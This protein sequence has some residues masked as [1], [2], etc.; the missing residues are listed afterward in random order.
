[1]KLIIKKYKLL[2]FALT[3]GVISSQSYAQNH[4][5]LTFIENKGQWP[6]TVKFS[7]SI[8]G[9]RLFIENNTLT[10]SFTDPT[11]TGK[12][13]AHSHLLNNTGLL[14][15]KEYHALKVEFLNTNNNLQTK[16]VEPTITKYNYFFGSDET[17]W[18]TEAKGYPKV[19][20]N[21]LY[22]GISLEI[23]SDTDKLKYDFIIAPGANPNCIQMQYDGTLAMK[24]NDETL[25][26]TTPY[27]LLTEVI[28]ASYAICGDIARNVKTN[29]KL[30]GKVVSF[31][32]SH[33]ESEESIV[34]DPLLIF[35]T[36][37][38]SVANNWGNTATYDDFGNGYS[39]G[40]T[41]SDR[42]GNYLGEFPATA[43]AFQTESGGGWDVAILKYDSAGQNLLYATHLGGG[44]TDVPQSLIV[45]E[46]GE[47]LIL[48]I[49]G[50]NDF[51]VTSN[52]YDQSF[53]GGVN[54]QLL[55]GVD[56]PTGS[57]LFIAKLS[58]DGSQLLASTYIGGSSNDGWLESENPL[59]K[60]YGDES[61]GDINFDSQGNILVS[62][63]TASNDFPTNNGYD[64]SYGGGSVD[65]VVFKFSPNLDNLQWSTF[66]GGTGA[67]VALSIKL[68]SLDNIFVA[69]GTTSADFPTT[70]NTFNPSYLGNADGWIAHITKQGDSLLSST[71]IG[72][73][74]YDQVFFL[75][76]DANGDVYIAGQTLGSYPITSGVF[77]QGTTGQ[78]IHKLTPDL[79]TSLFST[80]VSANNRTLPSISLTAFLVNDCDNIYLA[81]WGSPLINFSSEDNNNFKL[82]TANLPI[83]QDAFQSNSDGSSF[84]LMVLSGDASELL[85]ATH[86]GDANSSVHVDGGTS[87]FDKHGLVYHSVCASCFGDSMFPTTEGAWSQVNG[88]IGCNNAFFKFDLASLKAR[89][90][91][92]NLALDNPGLSG[93]CLP[94]HIAFENL[95]IGGD[96]Y[97]WDFG[98][99][100]TRVTTTLDTVVHQYTEAGTYQIRLRAS[101]VNTCISEDFAY[102]TIIVSNPAFSISDDVDI[103]QGTSTQLTALGGSIFLW[104]PV[105]GL[106]DSTIFNPVATPA[107]TTTYFVQI[108]N[109]NGCKH[110]DSVTVNVIPD[111]EI[112][113][114][115]EK[116]DLCQDS[117]K[118]VIINESE[119][120]TNISWEMGDG[121]LLDSGQVVYEYTEDGVYKILGKFKN[122]ACKK[123]V[124]FDLNVQKLFIPN[125]LTRNQDGLNDVLK[126]TSSTPVDLSIFTRW[127]TLV[128]E[129]LDYKNNWKGEGLNNGVYY[130]QV[131]LEN[132]EVCN[133]WI[134][135]LDGN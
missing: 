79:Q 60:N 33:V 110:Q 5:G 49:T 135:L 21:N 81:G 95:S 97:E 43:G 70:S 54:Y 72:T 103:C 105:V 48:G 85:Y 120:V 125:V 29:Y 117:R 22:E 84:Y 51:P 19:V 99:G 50:S 104:H 128:Y 129:E 52:A 115:I 56:F 36:Y 20:I 114:R 23:S 124:E 116:L 77:S 57:D 44:G 15:K 80:I 69:G 6:Q 26:I 34:I 11:Y 41:K 62:S 53:N 94:L 9:G 121:M 55:G 75:D 63:R 89:I 96:L 122:Q 86:L 18:A 98:D 91:T 16:G 73:S 58:S 107:E 31:E 14:T 109:N 126:I 106:S 28:P 13:V 108:F 100:S 131:I 40:M 42:G 2:L 65:G 7:A 46:N 10:Y 17:K 118:I 4:T 24:I 83:T 88:S 35:S 39:G 87:R 66:L 90:Q 123:D 30:E 59:A 61:R 12:N 101:D 112:N 78:F 102:A 3:L 47:L 74:T 32:L 25:H 111:I 27:Q 45:N 82:N 134:H 38:G 8:P 132:N 92:N 130:Y 1:M 127:G 67:D 113:V 64:N 71:F 68:D 76:L 133:G 119:N 37:S 93:G